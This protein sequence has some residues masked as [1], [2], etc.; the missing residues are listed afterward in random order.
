MIKIKQPILLLPTTGIQT[1]LYNTCITCSTQVS[2][3]KATA[4]MMMNK[5]SKIMF[6]SLQYV[7]SCITTLSDLWLKDL[8]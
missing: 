6:F 5:A 8:Q 3:K 4:L 2:I 7:F 1:S